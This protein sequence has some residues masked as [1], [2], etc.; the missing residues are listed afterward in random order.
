[1]S[2]QKFCVSKVFRLPE[3]CACV[4]EVAFL[5]WG[6]ASEKETL[7]PPPPPRPVIPISQELSQYPCPPGQLQGLGT[8]LDYNQALDIAVSQIAVQI[9]SSV[10]AVNTSRRVSDMAADGSEKITENF[11]T[12]SQVSAQIRNRQDVRVNQT[13]ARDGVVGIVACMERND[14]A[15]PYRL[16]Y[17]TARDQLVST[18]AIL[19]TTNHPL[20]KFSSYDNLIAAYSKY[21]E[22]AMVLHSLGVDEGGSEIEL[23]YRKALEG[24]NEYRASYKLYMGGALD[25]DEGRYVFGE[26]SKNVKLQ[27]LEDSCGTGV[28][29]S[30]EVSDPK[31]KEGGL[32]VSCTEVIALNGKSCSGESYFT[33]GGTFKGVG[34]RDEDEAREKLLN[35]LSRNDFMGEWIKEINR[36]IAR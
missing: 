29:L 25:T 36:W 15:K 7:V 14:A 8:A 27:S 26:I 9:Q 3:M 5:M 1:M 30:L 4:A 22:S 32:G 10:K 16:D 33:L 18:M 28:V 13:L 23:D 12:N 31:C 24:Y 6:C 34:R 19:A 35:G 17:Q 20:E 21:Q 2:M 11:Q